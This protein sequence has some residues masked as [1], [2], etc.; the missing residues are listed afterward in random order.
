MPVTFR[1]SLFVFT[2]V[3]TSISIA[4]DFE[5]K[6]N[7]PDLANLPAPQKSHRL[8][9]GEVQNL[10]ANG[11]VLSTSLSDEGATTILIQHKDRL[12]SCKIAE[13]VMSC[14]WITYR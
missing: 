11:N 6:I 1:F 9:A 8:S 2:L 12:S 5:N 13:L 14:W 3:M 7:V 10:L 4:E